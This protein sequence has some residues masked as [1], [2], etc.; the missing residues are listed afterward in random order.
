MRSSPFATRSPSARYVLAGWVMPP[1]SP[2]NPVRWT[3]SAPKA[4]EKQPQAKC[5]FEFIYFSRP[6]SM[7]FGENVDKIRRKLGVVLARNH[8]VDADI[9][10]AVPDSSNT[11]SLG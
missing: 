7:V 10:I 1:S 2:A 6:D 3:S 11:S 9:C 4:F 5:I 8:P